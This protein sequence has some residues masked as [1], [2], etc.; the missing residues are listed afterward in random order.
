MHA[1]RLAHFFALALLFSAVSA[2]EEGFTAD[3]SGAEQVP[4]VTSAATG[5]A[6][7]RVSQDALSI[8]FDLS[9]SNIEDV[10]MAHIHLA[11]AG[12]NG[13]VV[14]WLYPSGP[15]PEP[16]PGRS[17]GRLAAGTITEDGLLGPLQGQPLAELIEAFLRGEAYVN[18]HTQSH[19]PG[20][21]R[22]Q[23]LD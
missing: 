5:Q 12:Q 1:A 3:L 8:D 23:I 14:A 9:V 22:G 7:F 19:P 10:T 17:D 6:V 4:P 2:E 11:P 16:I 18:V 20:E 21:I 13:P 15:P